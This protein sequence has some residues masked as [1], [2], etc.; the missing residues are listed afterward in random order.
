M[1]FTKLNELSTDNLILRKISENDRTFISE[2]FKD[3]DVLKNYI[4]PKEANQD[5]RNLMNYWLNDISNNSGY[6]WIIFEKEHGWFSREKPC[7]FFSFEFRGSLKNARISFALKPE[8]R[9]KGI[10]IKTA[11]FVI[12]TLKSLGVTSVEADVNADNLI[13]EKVVEKL[14]FSTNKKQAIVDPEMM[15]DIKN[16]RFRHL[17]VKDLTLKV[18]K[19]SQVKVGRIPLDAPQLQLTNA[20]N[21]I[22]NEIKTSGKH[23]KLLAK[24]FYL[25]GRIKFNDGRFDEAKEAFGQCNMI[26]Y[27]SSLP[28]NHETYYWFARMRELDGKKED[29]KMYYGFALEKF[30]GDSDLITKMEIEKAMSKL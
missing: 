7:G 20:I 24:Y 29:A 11:K 25:L 6:T 8:H 21:N 3:E 30:S 5:Y 15:S 18:I 14:G 10:I 2:M 4:V 27:E 13:S 22:G 23:P 9:R 17:W 26:T 12:E 28:E 1:D 19:E 16:M